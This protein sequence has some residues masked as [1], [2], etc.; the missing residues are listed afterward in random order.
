[1]KR[2]PVRAL[3]LALWLLTLLVGLWEIVIVRDMLFRVYA[4]IVGTT[5]AHDAKY[6]GAVSL[7]NWA[8]LFLGILWLGLAIGTGEYHYRRAGQRSSW[9]LFGWTIGGELLILLLALII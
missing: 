3:A 9:R 2:L 6:W 5:S 4:R 8:V 7:G 1:M